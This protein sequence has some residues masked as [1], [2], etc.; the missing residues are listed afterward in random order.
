MNR[1]Y[2]FI[3]D[4]RIGQYRSRAKDLRVAKERSKGNIKI[5]IILTTTY[6]DLVPKLC[7]ATYNTCNGSIN[8][9]TDY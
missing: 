2:A 6:R 8:D 1:P 5:G 7:W 3:K 4:D 9:L